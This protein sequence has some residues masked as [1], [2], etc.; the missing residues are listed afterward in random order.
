MHSRG[1]LDFQDLGLDCLRH[2]GKGTLE[3]RRCTGRCRKTAGSCFDARYRPFSHP[4]ELGFRL[5]LLETTS[6]G[7]KEGGR[8]LSDPPT[9]VSGGQTLGPRI[10]WEI[11]RGKGRMR[12]GSQLFYVRLGRLAVTRPEASLGESRTVPS[13]V[14]ASHRLEP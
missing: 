1:G 10:P 4:R 3:L 6:Q 5:L 8:K 13:Q 12:M 14:S 2:P 9:E 11:V 7:W